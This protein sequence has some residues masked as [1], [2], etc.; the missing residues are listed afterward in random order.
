MTGDRTRARKAARQQMANL[1]LGIGTLAQRAEVNE[2]TVS[3]FM[4][5]KR[6][7]R[8]ANLA[9]IEKALRW[10]AGEID[11]LASGEASSV[12]VT[13]GED[14]VLLNLPPSALEGLSDAEREEVIARA[15]ASALRA[16]RE[17]RRGGGGQ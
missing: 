2:D 13:P 6:W 8:P 5:G 12:D 3:D 14:G 1:G 15:K 17:I 11:R 16:A 7:P 9:K 10:P 4:S